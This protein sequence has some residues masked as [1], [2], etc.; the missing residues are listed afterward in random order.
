MYKRLQ[1]YKQEQHLQQ[2]TIK[3]QNLSPPIKSSFGYYL[4]AVS[5]YLE[6]FFLAKVFLRLFYGHYYNLVNARY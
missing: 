1:N 3:C 4:M 6:T 2:R 5:I